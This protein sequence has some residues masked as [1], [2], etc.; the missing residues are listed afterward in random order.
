MALALRP[1]L[2]L[3]LCEHSALNFASSTVPVAQEVEK[4]STAEP[5]DSKSAVQATSHARCLLLTG[6]ACDPWQR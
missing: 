6:M 5:T 2:D 1:D 3:C 4:N